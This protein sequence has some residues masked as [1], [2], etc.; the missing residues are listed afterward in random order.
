MEN[1]GEITKGKWEVSINGMSVYN[2][3]SDDPC[4]N[5]TISACGHVGMS[6]KE[7]EANVQLIA[8]A[9]NVTNESGFTPR[10]LLEQRDSLL[11]VLIKSRSWMINKGIDIDR[12]LFKE[13]ELEIKKAK[14]E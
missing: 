14:G 2:N 7:S 6:I 13:L 1:I 8:E 9:G 3:V 10:E 11:E 4:R 12:K 5:F